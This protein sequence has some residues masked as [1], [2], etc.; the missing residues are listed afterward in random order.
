M[1]EF[2]FSGAIA[3]ILSLVW[4]IATQLLGSYQ[5]RT[6]AKLSFGMQEQLGAMQV[7]MG[8]FMERLLKIEVAGDGPEG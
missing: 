6:A 3:G 8:Q 4:M 2:Q 7:Q 1:D 5:E